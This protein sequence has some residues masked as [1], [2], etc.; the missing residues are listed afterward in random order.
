MQPSCICQAYN[1]I[2]L[3]ISKNLDKITSR[4]LTTRSKR[5]MPQREYKRAVYK[6]KQKE[7]L[8]PEEIKAIAKT[9][10]ILK[11]SHGFV[12]TQ[13]AI[14]L[15]FSVELKGNKIWL[16]ARCKET[17]LQKAL[18]SARTNLKITDYIQDVVEQMHIIKNVCSVDFFIEKHRDAN[19]YRGMV[20]K[21]TDINNRYLM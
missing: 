8:Q 16:V 15:N 1:N 12:A 4:N 5:K 13:F 3:K 17:E 10:Q 21:R 14:D 19:H 11:E 6:N 2:L 18:N 20:F 9:L 7:K